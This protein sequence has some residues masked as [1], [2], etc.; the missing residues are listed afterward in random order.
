[1][2]QGRLGQYQTDGSTITISNDAPAV[3]GLIDGNRL[4]K[5]TYCIA[6]ANSSWLKQLLIVH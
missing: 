3:K 5:Y 1:M 2:T 4:N 6:G